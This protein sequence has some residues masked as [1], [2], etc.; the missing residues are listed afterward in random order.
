M[1]FKDSKIIR[2]YPYSLEHSRLLR[3]PSGTKPISVSIKSNAQD[4]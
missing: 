2:V 1:K 4:F 3:G